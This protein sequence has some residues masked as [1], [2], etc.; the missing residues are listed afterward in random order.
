MASEPDP[1]RLRD[2]E[3]RRP[4]PDRLLVFVLDRLVGPTPEAEAAA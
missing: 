2:L 4:D 1:D 3:A